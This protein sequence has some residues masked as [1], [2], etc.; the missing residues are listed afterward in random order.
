MGTSTTIACIAL[1]FV[2][3]CVVGAAAL[4]V[5]LMI[6]GK[7]EAEATEAFEAAIFARD[8]DFEKR[9]AKQKD[10]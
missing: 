2:A 5:Y 8:D 7:T 10:I 6:Y 1:A 3:G 4:A 9:L